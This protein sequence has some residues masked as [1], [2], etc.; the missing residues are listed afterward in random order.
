MRQAKYIFIIIT[1]LA[2]FTSCGKGVDNMGTL[3]VSLDFQTFPA[4]Y[5]C[6]G[7]DISPPIHIKGIPHNTGA[8]AIIMDDPDAPIG[9]FTH[10]IAWNITPT[11]S[12]PADIPK[13]E[14]AHKEHISLMQ[15][16]NDF[17]KIGYG[18]PCPPRGH[19]VHHYHIKVYALDSMLPLS[20]KI[21]RKT[22]E[23]AMKEHIIASGEYI[24]TYER[25]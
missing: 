24:A 15:G 21:D 12:I 3:Q 9:T 5:T 23:R 20:G 4:Q 22:L 6:D 25:K 19:G 1:L 10:W 11:E 8:L 17:R 7:Q 16:M 13:I 2:V 14:R 18:G